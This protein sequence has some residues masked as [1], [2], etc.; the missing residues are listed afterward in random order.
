MTVP[1]DPVILL[2]YINTK[3]RDFYP[4]FDELCTDLSLDPREIQ[5]ALAQIDYCYDRKQNQFI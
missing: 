3:L 4:D 5:E 1:K 2:S